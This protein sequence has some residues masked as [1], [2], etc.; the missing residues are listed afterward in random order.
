MKR[1]NVLGM[2]VGCYLAAFKK[3]D[4]GPLM[5][6]LGHE[7][8]VKA[9][10]AEVLGV[11]PESVR[12]WYQEFL[13][14]WATSRRGELFPGWSP[15][16]LK[17]RSR[18]PKEMRESRSKMFANFE[19]KPEQE[20][21]ETCKAILDMSSDPKFDRGFFDR[22]AEPYLDKAERQTVFSSSEVA[23]WAA[24][25]ELPFVAKKPAGNAK[26]EKRRVGVAGYVF[27]RGLGVVSCDLPRANGFCELCS[28]LGPFPTKDGGR[29]L[30]VH[31]VIPLFQGGPDTAENVAAV[32]PNC[33]RA[34]HLAPNKAELCQLLKSRTA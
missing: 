2:A 6:G 23:E 34:C 7:D 22:L 33:H 20:L 28:N 25:N 3:D 5:L 13:P 12:Q 17:G 18:K 1:H 11:A 10:A 29:F 24:A 27:A 21:V 30:E 16:G 31:H 14:Y 15:S 32:C 9:K 4:R 26:P 19:M 8:E